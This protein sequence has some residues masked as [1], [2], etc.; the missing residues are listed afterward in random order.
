[1]S[2]LS[3]FLFLLCSSLLYITKAGAGINLDNS[4]GSYQQQEVKA[5]VQEETQ[6]DKT[7]FWTVAVFGVDSRDDN[8]GKG[9]L[10][11]AQ[12]VCSIDKSTGEIR[13]ASVYRDTF[14]KYGP[15]DRF[16]KINNAYFEG[17]PMENVKALNENLDLEIQDYISFSWKSAVEAVNILGGI[18]VNITEK[19][20]YF[21]NSYITE[22]VSVTGIGSCLLMKP[23]M[24]HLDG[25]Q[26]IA[27]CRLRLSDSDQMRTGR[28]RL[29][30]NKVLEKI[31]QADLPVLTELLATVL[32]M[33]STSMDLE[34]L[35]RLAVDSRKYHIVNEGGFP[36][37]YEEVNFGRKGMCLLPK[38]LE[39]NVEQLHQLL[40]EKGEYSCSET[41]KEIGKDLIKQA[42]KNT[43]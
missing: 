2:L 1:M 31:K 34:D 6:E 25:V 11:D 21:I 41:V 40:Y 38:I 3:L 24:Q 32:P 15:E 26:T 27:Y 12:L 7:D 30:L 39:S 13:I 20:F 4:D 10:A 14:L 17:G 43:K 19:E 42:I 8:V 16:G 36:F 33:T 28:Q 9:A 29:V 22:T 37:E 18:E 35:T 23:G 5:P